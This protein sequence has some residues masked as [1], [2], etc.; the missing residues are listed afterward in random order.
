MILRCCA[1]SIHDAC[2]LM[3]TGTEMILVR[4]SP[5]CLTYKHSATQHKIYFILSR[6][7]QYPSQQQCTTTTTVVV[8]SRTTC[9]FRNGL[10]SFL[11]YTLE[12]MKSR[13]TELAKQCSHIYCMSRTSPRNSVSSSFQTFISTFPSSR[14]A[15]T[16]S[17]SFN[18]HQLCRYF[19]RTC[20]VGMKH[21]GFYH[22]HNALH[23]SAVGRSGSA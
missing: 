3:V 21:A 2:Q 13:R 12:R 15:Y 4:V 14:V 10:T 7:L 18:R 6:H 16:Q 19:S 5:P 22:H 8:V 17:F 20:S 23:T 1:Y 9:S 11:S